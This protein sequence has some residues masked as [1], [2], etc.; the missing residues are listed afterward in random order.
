VSVARF[1][2]A[3][4][5]SPGRDLA[6]PEI[7]DRSLARSRHRRYLAEI[8]RRAR[9]RRQSISVAVSALLAA[10]PVL[11]RS[12]AAAATGSGTA[13]P[14]SVDASSSHS[15]T[16][17][18]GRVVL[19]FGSEGRLVAAAQ[20]RLNETLPVTH[21]A[22]DG[23]Y[24]PLTKAAV[25]EYQSKHQ[26]SATGSLDVRSWAMLFNAPVVAFSPTRT[27]ADASDGASTGGGHS[28]FVSAHAGAGG[29]TAG[30][31]Q[32]GGSSQRSAASSGSGSS[33]SGSSGSGS[34]GSGSSG[35]ASAPASGGGGSSGS[36]GTQPVAVITPPTPSP[37]TTSTYVLTNG[38]ALPLPRGYIS[39]G[40]VDQGVDYAAP[41]GTPLYAMGN[42]VIIGEG[43]SGFGPNAPVLKITSG[44]LNG[45]EVY[46]GHAGS[47]SV[48]IGD[49][50][51]AGQQIS[52]VGYGIVGI[53]TGPHLEIG[54]YPP[55][56]MG[57]GSRMKALIDRLLGEHPSGRVWGTRVKKAHK[58][59][60]VRTAVT[61]SQTPAPQVTPAAAPAS[62]PT[63]RVASVSAST[64]DHKTARAA[65]TVERRRS[66]VVASETAP[67]TS[68]RAA[69]N[70]RAGAS[71]RR[72]RTTESGAASLAASSGS[73]AA[74]ESA[75]SKESTASTE[76]SS[77]GATVTP[78]R[79]TSSHVETARSASRESAGSNLNGSGAS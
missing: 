39:G 23:I 37:N 38:V 73:P 24:G 44:P 35:Q 41:G 28:Q 13:V 67:R 54:F 42:G 12:K 69:E 3:R 5:V 56:P 74:R 34:S 52:Q 14:G 7:W 40:S 53:S 79:Q 62:A 71:A 9:R 30:A 10:T 47:N 64:T 45:L 68:I 61:T 6:S 19:R 43:I 66:R 4:G 48:H 33:G 60:V 57:A 76:T 18:G 8:G 77:S 20:R 63:A 2:P 31:A 21:L 50:V 26:L 72:A 51:R 17:S 1:A 29:G 49:H 36:S 46:Y 78:E 27:S 70:T 16:A 75:P 15:L 22:V 25:S 59:R 32:P 65:L 11:P 55:G 58:A